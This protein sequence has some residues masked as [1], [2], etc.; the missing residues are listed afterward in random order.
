[1]PW[2]RREVGLCMA[3][4]GRCC[5]RIRL[6]R[7]KLGHESPLLVFEG[8]EIRN[9]NDEER[10]RQK[11]MNFV[12]VALGTLTGR[13][14]THAWHADFGT[15][16][17]PSVLARRRKARACLEGANFSDAQL[18]KPEG[19]P[20]PRT[21]DPRGNANLSTALGVR[22]WCRSACMAD[23][24]WCWQ[25]IFVRGGGGGGPV[26]GHGGVLPK[27]RRCHELKSCSF[28]QIFLPS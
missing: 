5:S 21:N 6:G 20:Q 1:V 13:L 23:G 15:F 2:Q 19:F 17:P 8:G 4:Q 9:S 7:N 14:M 18:H 11:N 22:Q 25:G 16:L 27:R 10:A 3:R 26:Q 24:A 28:H 12:V